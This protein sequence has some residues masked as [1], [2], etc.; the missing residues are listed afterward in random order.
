VVGKILT[1]NKHKQ[2]D[3]LSL[4][5]ALEQSSNHILARAIVSAAEKKR[6]KVPKAKH[7]SETAGF[8][9]SGRLQNKQILVGRLRLLQ[10]EGV[11]VPKN[12]SKDLKQTATLV[13]IDNE[14]A[15]IITFTDEVRAE[16]KPMITRL[17][18]AGLKHLLMIT[19]DNAETARAVAKQVGIDQVEADCLPADKMHVLERVKDRPVAFVGDGVNDAPV[20]TAADV[21]IALGARGSTAASESADVVIMLDDVSKVATAVEVAKRTFSI[22]RQSILIGIFISLGLMVVFATGKF[23]AVQGAVIQELVDVTVILNALRAHTAPKG[24]RP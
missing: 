1:Y 4:A 21:G 5:A 2:D 12:I 19:G 7:V 14:L 6:L 23:T 17:K 18:A 15:G 10:K 3:V 9:L 24:Y 11:D 20:L 13:A 16:T 8:G 22:G